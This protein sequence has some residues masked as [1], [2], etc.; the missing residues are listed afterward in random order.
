MHEEIQRVQCAPDRVPI[1][2]KVVGLSLKKKLLKGAIELA[3]S[4]LL[5]DALVA[6]QALDDRISSRRD[7]LG[8]SRLAAARWS[9]Y[10][11][12]LLH[13]RSEVYNL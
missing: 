2:L 10:D 5:I 8:K 4:F 12:R 6:L 7:R 13:A 9:L 1:L 3:D 11:D